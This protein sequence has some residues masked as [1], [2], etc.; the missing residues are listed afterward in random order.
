MNSIR[1]TTGLHAF[2]LRVS[3]CTRRCRNCA[4]NLSQSELSSRFKH[5]SPRPLLNHLAQGL[6]YPPAT[7]LRRSGTDPLLALVTKGVVTLSEKFRRR[8]RLRPRCRI[9]AIISSKLFRSRPQVLR[10]TKQMGYS[11]QHL[12]LYFSHRT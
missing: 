4:K 12:S 5:L 6:Y 11:R 8:R 10:R 3:F 1:N 9:R 7:R 2:L